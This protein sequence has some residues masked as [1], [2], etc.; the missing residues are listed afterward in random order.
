MLMVSVTPKRSITYRRPPRRG[1]AGNSNFLPSARRNRLLQELPDRRAAR[2]RRHPVSA[3]AVDYV[4]QL[5]GQSGGDLLHDLII[6][7][8]AG[9][10]GH[11]SPKA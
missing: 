7:R 3:E 6:G 4:E 11:I 8:L 9:D 2:W 10:L 1:G 5:F